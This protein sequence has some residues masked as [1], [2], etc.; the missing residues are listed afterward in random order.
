MHNPGDDTGL[1][2]RRNMDIGY[3]YR[4]LEKREHWVLLDCWKYQPAF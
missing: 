2:K 1:D 4:L 3:E